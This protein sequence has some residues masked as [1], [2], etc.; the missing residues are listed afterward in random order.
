MHIYN[1]EHLNID[2]QTRFANLWMF[3]LCTLFILTWKSYV[4]TVV[5]Q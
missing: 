3:V 4:L 5:R 1:I 2:N